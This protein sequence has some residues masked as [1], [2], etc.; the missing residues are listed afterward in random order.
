MQQEH[1]IK[2]GQLGGDP[3]LYSGNETKYYSLPFRYVPVFPFSEDLVL[4]ESLVH[5][6]FTDMDPKI[7][8]N[9][10]R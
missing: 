1:S 5:H 7:P 9:R 3:R 10:S 4:S 6:T 8:R 2:A